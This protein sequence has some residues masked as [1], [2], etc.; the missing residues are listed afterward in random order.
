MEFKPIWD[1]TRHGS[2][3]D[4]V[5]VVFGIRPFLAYV[6]DFKLAVGRDKRRLDW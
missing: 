1:T 3:M 4:K 6:V 2:D 5:E